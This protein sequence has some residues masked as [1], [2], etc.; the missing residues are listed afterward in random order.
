MRSTRCPEG[1]SRERGM[2]RSGGKRSASPQRAQ[3]E[4]RGQ[5]GRREVR[6][7]TDD[8]APAARFVMAL[9]FGVPTGYQQPQVM[10]GLTVSNLTRHAIDSGRWHYT[11]DVTNGG[12]VTALSSRWGSWM[13]PDARREARPLVAAMLQREVGNKERV[14][15]GAP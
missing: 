1:R 14:A 8:L 2:W 12:D 3:P 11:A 15:R 4:Q 13:T 7:T 6:P 9:N 5:P 10:V